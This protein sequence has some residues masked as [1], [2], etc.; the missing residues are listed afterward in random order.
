MSLFG[1]HSNS[2]SKEDKGKGK[3]RT[4]SI[5]HA[6]TSLLGSGN[7]NNVGGASS[8]S[9]N[10]VASKVH[11]SSSARRSSVPASSAM[12]TGFSPMMAFGSPYSLYTPQD[13]GMAQNELAMTSGDDTDFEDDDRQASSSL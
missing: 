12:P 4:S 13:Y 5:K 2:S 6:F 11:R 3:L 1:S 7:S 8:G 10:A 9:N